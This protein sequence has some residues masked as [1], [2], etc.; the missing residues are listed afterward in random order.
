MRKLLKSVS[1]ECSVL[2][3]EGC[4]VCQPTDERL[5]SNDI[6]RD[7]R[8]VNPCKKVEEVEVQV[9]KITHDGATYYYREAT[10]PDNP[11]GFDFYKFN[12]SVQSL[13]S[14]DH[15]DPVINELLDIVQ[16]WTL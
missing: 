15:S 10:S 11:L 6:R 9:K 14:I 16:P 7:L 8:S 3:L 2:G 1:L 12:E 4:R 5:Y 13:V